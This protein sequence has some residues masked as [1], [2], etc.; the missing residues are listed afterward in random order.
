MSKIQDIISSLES[1]VEQIEDVINHHD[2]KEIDRDHSRDY[3]S[4][5]RYKKLLDKIAN[6]LKQVINNLKT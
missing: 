6:E 2:T 3:E 1:M 4:M 5:E